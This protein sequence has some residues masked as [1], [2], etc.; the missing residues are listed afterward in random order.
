MAPNRG[1]RYAYT[2]TMHTSALGRG[3]RLAVFVVLGVG[4]GLLYGKVDR[5][6]DDRLVAGTLTGWLATV[7]ASFGYA[8]PI[9]TGTLLAA[10]TFS[11]HERSS[12]A[13]REQ[14]RA[15]SLQSRL[16]HVE[17]DQAV[18]VMAASV[19]HEVRNPLHALGLL[20]DDL[21]RIAADRDPETSSLLERSRT[22]MERIAAQMDLL[23]NLRASTAP[24]PSPTD[25]GELVQSV[26]DGRANDLRALG[27]KPI[28]RAPQRIMVM[29]D[30][31]YIRI[32]L[33][34]LL[35]NSLHALRGER[36]VR[37]LVLDVEKTSTG[38][39]VRVGDSGGGVDRE[40]E[41]ILFSPFG[42]T[43]ERG[44]G[45][46]LP[47]AR[48]LA[49]AMEGDLRFEGRIAGETRFALELPATTAP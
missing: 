47:I 28:V 9:L 27:T 17:R 44:L 11:W 29:G 24:E 10:V 13:K 32:I 39:V 26:V 41:E 16:E 7:H 21:A 5:G 30:P 18:W 1:Q 23:R 20:L 4:A 37:E 8:L 49:R 14:R 25:L 43:K 6:F 45:L 33:E 38:A 36:G 46:G 15:T 2:V 42:S 40:K 19:L 31:I 35:D 48:A 34:N 3:L 12:L 22:H